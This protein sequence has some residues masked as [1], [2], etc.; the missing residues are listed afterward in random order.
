[1]TMELYRYAFHTEVPLEE[2]EVTLLLAL[3]AAESLHG[4]SQ[5]QLDAAHHLDEGQVA[6]VIDAGTL[7]GRDLNRLFVGFLR[8]E[9]GA[10]A[11]QVERVENLT[12][13]PSREVP[14]AV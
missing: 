7:V 9:F 14:A 5:V 12:V 10:D 6:L 1:M 13:S 3:F 4:E 8:R 2:I 11:F